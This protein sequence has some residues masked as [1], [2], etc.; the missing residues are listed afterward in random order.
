MFPVKDFHKNFIHNHCLQLS[1]SFSVARKPIRLSETVISH[2][3]FHKNFERTHNK[4]ASRQYW[5]FKIL[6]WLTWEIKKNNKK[7]SN[8]N[9]PFLWMGLNCLKARATSWSSWLLTSLLFAVYFL[10]LTFEISNNV[11]LKR[12]R[13]LKIVFWVYENT[14]F[15]YGRYHV[16]TMISIQTKQLMN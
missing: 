5:N 16:F 6:K 8:L 11:R 1:N 14:F 13:K 9:G 3:I 4:K 15:L 10:L 7:T 2:D 12:T